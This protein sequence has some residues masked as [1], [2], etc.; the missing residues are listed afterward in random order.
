M[1]SI[2]TYNVHSFND[3]QGRDAFN[4]VVEVLQDAQPDILCLQEVHGFGLNKLRSAL[5]YQHGIKWGGCAILSNLYMEEV[6]VSNRKVRKGYHPRF[7]AARL[8]VHDQYVHV[9]CCHLNHKDELKRMSELRKMK[10]QLADLYKSNEPHIWTG[11][12]NSL[13]RE[14]YSE[15]AWRKITEVRKDNHWELPKT[16]VLYHAYFGPSGV[17]APAVS[18]FLDFFSS[19]RC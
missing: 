6:E 3:E 15:D 7:P 12:F 10:E 1:F 2:C 9:T 14:D 8:S 5:S 16:Q 13:T 17:R 19:Y 18:T 4:R 11:D